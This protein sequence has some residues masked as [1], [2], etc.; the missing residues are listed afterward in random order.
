[1]L[2]LGPVVGLDRLACQARGTWE[3][4]MF[5]SGP[6][7]AWLAASTKRWLAEQEHLA[8]TLARL[9]IFFT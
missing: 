3:M 2:P 4:Y 8:R 1:M 7:F 5:D 6:L 9:G